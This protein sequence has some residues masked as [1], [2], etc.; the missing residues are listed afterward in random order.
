MQ[1]FTAGNNHRTILARRKENG[2]NHKKLNI[3]LLKSKT[4][5]KTH[6]NKN[7]NNNN[8][9][10]EPLDQEGKKSETKEITE[11]ILCTKRT[12]HKYSY[13]LNSKVF[14]WK[15]YSK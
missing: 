3:N 15:N 7:S 4:F 5:D 12:L 8:E 2:T 10:K 6:V 9:E 1:T 11:Q 14:A 13:R